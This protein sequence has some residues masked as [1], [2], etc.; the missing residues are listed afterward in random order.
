LKSRVRNTN[1]SPNGL[2]RRALALLEQ[3]LDAALLSERE[4]RN[5]RLVHYIEGGAAIAQAN[6]IFGFDAWGAEL[7]GD[8]AFRLMS[9]SDPDTGERL[10]VGMYSATVR[11]VVRGC[12]PRIDVG[13][14]FARYDTPEAHEAAFKGAVTDATKRCLRLF[15]GQFGN[16]LYRRGHVGAEPSQEQADPSLSKVEE[17][18]RRLVDLSARLG[19]DEAKAHA[20]AEKRYGQHI[21]ELTAEQ[22]ADAVRFLADQLN[23][24]NGAGNQQRANREKAA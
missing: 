17:M 18:R 21:E 3:P 20:W 16:E 23:R 19:A 11:V 15:G 5:G 2:P 22:L 7:V 4:T 13:C 8:V 14:A 10:A 12:L 1:A 24:R 6:R 9:L